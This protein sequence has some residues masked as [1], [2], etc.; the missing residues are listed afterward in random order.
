M[1]AIREELGI[2]DAASLKS[3]LPTMGALTWE[4][5]TSNGIVGRL[6]WHVVTMTDFSESVE[7]LGFTR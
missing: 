3:D 4:V 6:L 1:S 2:F 5:D 7:Y